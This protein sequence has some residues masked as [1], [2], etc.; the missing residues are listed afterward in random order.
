MAWF[1]RA[2]EEHDGRWRCQHGRE[3][4]DRHDYLH[5]AVAHL[6]SIAVALAP[7]ELFIHRLDGTIEKRGPINA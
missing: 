7:A 6:S 5:E 3:A 2:I 4:Y 1:L